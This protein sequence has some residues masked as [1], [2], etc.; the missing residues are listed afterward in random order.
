MGPINYF[1][2][3]VT[4]TQNFLDMTLLNNYRSAKF[5]V[6]ANE[7][8]MQDARDTVVLAVGASYLQ[9]IAAKARVAS[10]R[11]QMRPRTRFITRH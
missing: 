8:A 7:A 6:Q 4:L 5:V 9:V 10:E 11:A 3:R 2:L 1:D